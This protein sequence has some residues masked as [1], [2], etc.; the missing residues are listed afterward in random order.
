ML[1]TKMQDQSTGKAVGKYILIGDHVVLY[2]YEALCLPILDAETVV[3]LKESK[4][5]KVVCDKGISKKITDALKQD[6]ITV[7]SWFKDC[8]DKNYE[9]KVKFGVPIGIGAGMSA[10]W[11]VALIRAFLN[12]V[13]V[14]ANHV[15]LFEMAQELENRHHGKSSGIDLKTIIWETPVAVLE[16]LF[17]KREITK[18]DIVLVNT[19]APKE[20]TKDMVEL[21]AKK[22]E[23]NPEILSEFDE[24][25]KMHVKDPYEFMDEFG[26]AL[27]KLGVVS[28][29][30]CEAFEEFRKKG[31]KV[32]I[33]GGGGIHGGAGLCLVHHKDKKVIEDWIK[34]HS[35]ARIA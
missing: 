18:L 23:Q 13:E 16:G 31:G 28:K 12:L 15:E 5:D 24:I 20:I 22:I 6:L 27:E 35:F 33:S 21:V 1:K 32:K 3:E 17:N 19:G 4:D 8:S 30:V 11:S 25:Y 14:E 26:K 9:V 2:G 29:P 34:S 10:S 7:K